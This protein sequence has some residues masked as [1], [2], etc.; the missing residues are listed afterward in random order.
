MVL[1]CRTPSRFVC[2][3]A[4]ERLCS[5]VARPDST[6]VRA[7]SICIFPETICWAPSATVMTPEVIFSTRSA[8]APLSSLKRRISSCRSRSCWAVFSISSCS[9]SQS[10]PRAARRRSSSARSDS[11]RI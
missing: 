5:N 3:R 6:W 9:R 10:A 2:S 7:V 4:E 8:T 1:S 11:R